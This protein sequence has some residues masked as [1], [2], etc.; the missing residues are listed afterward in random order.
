M[1]Y[2]YYINRTT[3][4]KRTAVFLVFSVDALGNAVAAEKPRNA[5]EVTLIAGKLRT[6]TT[7]VTGFPV[8]LQRHVLGTGTA[9][10]RPAWGDETKM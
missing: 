2:Y 4:I 9:V 8:A 5:A 3:Q 6:G 10:R 7:Q 1:L